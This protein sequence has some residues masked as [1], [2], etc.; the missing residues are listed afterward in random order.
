MGRRR[1][2]WVQWLADEQGAAATEYGIL[3]SFIVV[4]TMSGAALFGIE[5]LG[6]YDDLTAYFNLMWG[7]P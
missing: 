2:R 5:L 7:T 4:V 1:Q 3:M 6:W